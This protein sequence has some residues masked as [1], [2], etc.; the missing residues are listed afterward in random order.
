MQLIP[1]MDLK[2]GECVRLLK[3]DFDA[4]T[5][6]PL[7][8]ESLYERYTALG[9]SWLHLVDLDGARQGVPAHA[10]VI[11]ALARRGRL[12]MQVGGGLRERA[13]VERTLAAG[14]ERVV[15][16]SLAVTDPDLVSTW[17]RKIGPDKLVLAFDVRLDEAGEPR[18]ATHGWATQSRLSLW[19]AVARYRHAGLRHVLCT[20]VARDGALAGPNCALY[21]DA[22]RRFPEIEWQASGGVRGACDLWALADGGVAAAI[23][24]RALI[25]ERLPVA[26]LRPFLPAA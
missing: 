26:E 5:H 14:V 8:P 9:A 21:V 15:I 18:V 24:G 22:V 3:G 11:G 20:D 2:G 23:S 7:T 1:A 10:G 12:R 6:Y 25:E 16:G 19:D 13:A 4:A 17:L